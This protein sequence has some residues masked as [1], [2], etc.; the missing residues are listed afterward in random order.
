VFEFLNKLRLEVEHVK[1][2]KSGAIISFLLV[3]LHIPNI[4]TQDEF[5]SYFLYLFGLNDE[6]SII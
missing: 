6:N 3:N 1:K 4:Y 2:G 5:P